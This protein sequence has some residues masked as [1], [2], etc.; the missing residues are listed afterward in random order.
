MKKKIVFL[1]CLCFVMPAMAAEPTCE[2]GTIITRNVYGTTGAPASC[3]PE[4]C[5]ATVKK[6]CVSNATMNWWTAFRPSHAV[7]C[8]TDA[9]S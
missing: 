5:P 1:M 2:G 6:F 8:R 4:K 7:E 3:T 9:L